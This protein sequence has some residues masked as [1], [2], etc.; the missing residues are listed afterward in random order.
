MPDQLEY[1]G[2][3][4]RWGTVVVRGPVPGIMKHVRLE[5]LATPDDCCSFYATG[6]RI[7]TGVEGFGPFLPRHE[8]EYTYLKDRD[9]YL[10]AHLDGTVRIFQEHSNPWERFLVLTQTELEKLHLFITND[11]I[12]ETGRKIGRTDIRIL[13]D[14]QIQV[15]DNI[16]SISE[17]FTSDSGSPVVRTREGQPCE[18]VLW[19]DRW[20]P[21]RYRLFRPLVYFCSFGEFYMN[22][23]ELSLQSLSEFGKYDGDILIVTDL[24]EDT[25]RAHCPSTAFFKC[26]IWNL[27]GQANLDFYAARFRITEWKPLYQFS[28]LLYMDTD[29]VVDKDINTSFETIFKSNSIS[30]Q[31]EAFS[32]IQ[33]GTSVGSELFKMDPRSMD[34]DLDKPGFNSGIISIPRIEDF[35][36]ILK[37]IH[38]CIYRFSEKMQNRKSLSH[39]DQSIA[40]YICT[41]TQSVDLK[42]LTEK[43]SYYWNNA[44]R[45]NDSHL[46]ER[47]KMLY[48]G[49]VHFW[50]TPD[51]T[52]AMSSYMQ[53]I[54][55]QIPF[56][57][58]STDNSESN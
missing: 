33:E 40:N 13:E 24:T 39:F 29:I 46:S 5:S 23:L 36:F 28:P 19:H 3:L 58:W 55:D 38:S 26:H 22:T 17:S 30:A 48:T 8:P 7:Q 9:G 50:G 15:G 6:L 51:R 18:I 20:M 49:F 47:P 43:V 52:R 56:E 31:M 2:L 53:S 44:I 35:D 32:T 34:F 54:R 16:F 57:G 10:T 37:I 4:T 27:H 11:W 45:M 21:H 41:I 42:F 12:D 1:C 14:F 25:L